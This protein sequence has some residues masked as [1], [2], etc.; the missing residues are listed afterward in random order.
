MIEENNLPKI[1]GDF[2]GYMTELAWIS[3]GIIYLINNYNNLSLTFKSVF[4]IMGVVEGIVFLKKRGK[5]YDKR[6]V[7]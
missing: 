1:I 2:I 6:K 4:A 7:N 3:Y 5:E